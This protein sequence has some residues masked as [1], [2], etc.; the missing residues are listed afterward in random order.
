[1]LSLP[2]INK[3]LWSVVVTIVSPVVLYAEDELKIR[4]KALKSH[5]NTRILA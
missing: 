5:E 1:M 4:Q 3:F 2:I